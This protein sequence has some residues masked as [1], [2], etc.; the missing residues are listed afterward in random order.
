M[1]GSSRHALGR[2]RPGI[3]RARPALACRPCRTLPPPTH[4][5]PLTSAPSPDLRSLPCP[6][7]CPRPEQEEKAI[8]VV[9]ANE[10][11][12]ANQQHGLARSLL[13]NMV[14][15]VDTGFTTKLQVG[16]WRAHASRLC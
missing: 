8:R 7:P 16:R 14:V 13:S 3:A 1:Q 9:R 2:R 10:T 4:R 6:C 11:R 5:A 15:G 12:T